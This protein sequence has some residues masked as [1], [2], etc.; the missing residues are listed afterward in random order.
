MGIGASQV[1]KHIESGRVELHSG[2]QRRRPIKAVVAVALD[3]AGPGVEALGQRHS[4]SAAD[5]YGFSR[6]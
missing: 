2:L 6:H 4:F 5:V 1:K 3:L